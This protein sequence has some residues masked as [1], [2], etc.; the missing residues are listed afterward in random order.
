MRHLSL[1]RPESA[2]SSDRPSSQRR[3]VCRRFHLNRYAVIPF[4][5]P[6]GL[7]LYEE[8]R[9]R[10]ANQCRDNGYEQYCRALR[11]RLQNGEMLQEEMARDNNW[12]VTWKPRRR[13][14]EGSWTHIYC[15]TKRQKR[16]RLL[17]I[18]TGKS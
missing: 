3:L 14:K 7:A 4:S 5:S 18:T 9:L 16:E 12:T 8:I 17:T 6:L 1:A 11:P 13:A 15:F 10:L 2:S